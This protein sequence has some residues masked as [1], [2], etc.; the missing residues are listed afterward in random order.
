MILTIVAVG[1]IQNG[2]FAINYEDK[3]NILYNGT[4]NFSINCSP[5]PIPT[6]T[7]NQATSL[8]HSEGIKIYDEKHVELEGI[9]WGAITL[10]KPGYY[11]ISVVNVGDQ[12]VIL[13]LS[14]TNWTP[15]VNGVVSWDYNGE[16][17]PVEGNFSIR[18]SLI[19][20]DATVNIFGNDIIISSRT[21]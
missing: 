4:K 14:V 11:Y 20:K 9:D 21:I 16:T 1:A 6:N 17:V 19:I 3:S 12:P 8:R 18:L 5:T 10:G 7:T 2:A 15:G 13:E